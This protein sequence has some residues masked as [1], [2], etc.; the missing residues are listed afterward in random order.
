MNNSNNLSTFVYPT[1]TK[2]YDK[3][4]IK[5]GICLF[6][7]VLNALFSND[8]LLLGFY[9]IATMEMLFG[10]I[11]EAALLLLM[12]APFSYAMVIAGKEYSFLLGLFFI[13]SFLLKKRKVPKKIFILLILYIVYMFVTMDFDKHMSVTNIPIRTV[14]AALILFVPLALKNISLKTVSKFV[15]ISFLLS[16]VLGLYNNKLTKLTQLIHSDAFWYES[17]TTYL[18][19]D[20]FAGLTYD[21]NFYGLFAIILSSFFIIILFEEKNNLKE[22]LVLWCSLV[23]LLI[24]GLYSMSKMFLILYVCMIVFALIFSNKIKQAFFVVLIIVGLY[25]Y[26]DLSNVEVVNLIKYRLQNN[27][28]TLNSYTTGRI[29]LW[30]VYIKEISNDS[31][32][33]I[34][35]RGINNGVVGGRAAH[36]TFLEV[37]S[38]FGL[39]GSIIFWSYI[40]QTFR[41][42]NVSKTK[43]LRKLPIILLVIGIFGLSVYSFNQ[44]WLLIVLAIFAAGGTNKN[45]IQYNNSCL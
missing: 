13:I 6:L 12:V 5:G 20:R 1:A 32:M 25:L 10:K 15:G 18:E 38:M 16:S 41:Y 9:L 34:I 31:K 44:T 11:D 40:I 45:E 24:F 33:F 19:V 35:G 26:F 3:A 27:D 29:N 7:V 37:F 17:G 39:I 42:F 4:F 43:V 36:N 21:P 8:I 30:L 2:Q 28:G 14:Q 23:M 22:R